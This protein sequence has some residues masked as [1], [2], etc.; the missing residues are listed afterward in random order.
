[1]TTRTQHLTTIT[2]QQQNNVINNEQQ[3]ILSELKIKLVVK[4]NNKIIEISGHNFFGEWTETDR[5]TAT[6]YNE[7][8]TVWETKPTETPQ[9]TSR[10]LMVPE[11]VTSPKTLQAV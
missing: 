2:T 11:Q 7:M 5:Q 8:S 1:M 6:L 4:K 10:L 3:N 9:S